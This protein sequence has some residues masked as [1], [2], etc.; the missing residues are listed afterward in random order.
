MP[1]PL[2]AIMHRQALN[3][4]RNA[5]GITGFE[6]IGGRKIPSILGLPIRAS[7]T[8]STSTKPA[9]FKE[10]EAMNTDKELL[11]SEKQAI[12]STPLVSTDSVLVTGLT[13]LDRGRHLRAFAQVETA[14]S[15]GAGTGIT[16]EIIQADDAALT[17]NVQSLYTTG[18]IVTANAPLGTRLIDQPLP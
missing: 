17:T 4:A 16:A 1:K 15:G 14:L 7:S 18:N 10:I 12:T 8:R 9:S 3:D 11:C 5:R 13:G 2:G 6:E